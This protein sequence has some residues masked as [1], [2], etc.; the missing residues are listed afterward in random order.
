M[1]FY[2]IVI[3]RLLLN[4]DQN[5]C[6]LSYAEKVTFDSADVFGGIDDVNDPQND[7]RKNV[8]FSRI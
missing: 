2:E 5:I 1:C 3:Q 6:I 4:I 8:K 7:A